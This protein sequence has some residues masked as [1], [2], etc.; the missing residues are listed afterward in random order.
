M[1]CPIHQYRHCNGNYWTAWIFQDFYSVGATNADRCTQGDKKSEC[2]WPFVIQQ[3]RKGLP[4]TIIMQDET[5]VH[6]SKSKSKWQLMECYHTISP[7][8]LKFKSTPSARKIMVKILLGWKRCHSCEHFAYGTT[9]NGYH[10][11]ETVT[12]LNVWL[13]EFVPQAKCLK[14]LLPP[15]QHMVK[16]KPAHNRG[17]HRLGN[18]SVATSTLQS[19]LRT[20]T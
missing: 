8:K 11:T 14:L 12:S 17:H 1:I 20:I 19:W 4:I 18:D 15:R 13:H 16:H 6:H 9:V 2:H 7:R 3:C 10:C 5:W